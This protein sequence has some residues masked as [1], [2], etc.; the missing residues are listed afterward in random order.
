[1]SPLL[2]GHSVFIPYPSELSNLLASSAFQ[3]FFFFFLIKNLFIFR[4]KGREGKRRETSPFLSVREKYQSVAPVHAPTRDQPAAQ[5][6]A[7][8]Q[9]N[10]TLETFSLCET[11]PSPLSHA[12]RDIPFKV[13]FSP[14]C[15]WILKQILLFCIMWFRKQ[16][17]EGDFAGVSLF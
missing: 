16:M 13:L 6:R 5:A 4:E 1:M 8:T 9:C 7:L 14:Y 12:G 15:P 17:R 11:R 3:G 2:K 10:L